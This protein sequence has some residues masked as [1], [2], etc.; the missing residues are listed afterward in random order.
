[1]KIDTGPA[2]QPEI[3]DH[4]PGWFKDQMPE[5]IAPYRLAHDYAY[6]L[7]WDMQQPKKLET[8]RGKVIKH[9]AFLR[10][11]ADMD[12]ALFDEVFAA[13]AERYAAHE[14]PATKP[15]SGAPVTAQSSNRTKDEEN[16]CNRHW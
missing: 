2:T 3:C 16:V 14:I 6:H 12:G 4:I 13:Y 8:A 15:K 1:M 7:I 9:W 5:D 11:L 10:L